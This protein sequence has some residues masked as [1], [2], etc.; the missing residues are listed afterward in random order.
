MAA[1]YLKPQTPLEQGTDYVYPVTTLDQ[2]IGSDGSTRLNTEVESIK[3]DIA[4]IETSST[5]AHSY[6]IGQY[7]VYNN[8]LYKATKAISVGATLVVGNNIQ[9]T[10][11]GTE[12]KSLNDE[13]ELFG[14]LYCIGYNY[15]ASM[16]TSASNT[17][18]MDFTISSPGIWLVGFSVTPNPSTS[19]FTMDVTTTSGSVS[20]V[21]VYGNYEI[22]APYRITSTTTF[23]AYTATSAQ[24]TWSRRFY[25]AVRLGTRP[26]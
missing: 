6:A 2:V 1:R 4:T 12:L 18:L 9:A 8:T 16:P 7:L 5:A 14:D 23:T 11:V 10:N 19:T 22:I 20:T 13:L 25:W 21:N 15:S 24:T 17:T 26:D 3:S